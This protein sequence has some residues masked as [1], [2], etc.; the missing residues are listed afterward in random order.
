M[1]RHLLLLAAATV[2]LASCG[3]GGGGSTGGGDTSVTPPPP[4]SPPP[5]PPPPPPPVASR[6]ASEWPGFV[7]DTFEHLFTLDPP[8]AVQEGRHEFDGRLPDWS[9]AGIQQ[10]GLFWHSTLDQANAFV[11]LDPAQSFER[12]Y[13]VQIAAGQ[14]F[15]LEDVD[16]PHTAPAFYINDGLDPDVYLSREYAD[17]L[18]RMQA[19]TAMLE[20]VPAA[21]TNIRANL[22]LPLAA[23]M[24]ANA[25][26]S[27]NGFSTYYRNNIVPVFAG[28]GDQAQRT[29]LANA[30]LAAANAMTD[31]VAFLQSGSG[32]TVPSFAFGEAKFLKMLNSNEAIETSLAELDS[33]AQADLQRNQSDLA[34]A[35]AT[36]APGTSNLNCILAMHAH[37][38]AGD[39]LATATSQIA[40]LRA[41]VSSHDLVTIPNTLTAG[42]RASPPYRGGDYF[43]PVGPYEQG[44]SAYYYVSANGGGEANRL[45]VTAHEVM[46]GHFLQFLHSNAAPS[47]VGR[48]F[49]TYGF[50][51][52]WGHYGEEML[53]EA[54]LRGTAE[55]HVG[56]LFN[57]LLRNCRLLAAIG[58]HTKGMSITQAQNLFQ[59]QCY[60]GSGTSA[61]EAQ[62]AAFDPL[63]VTYTLGKLMIRRLR[64]DWTATRGGT[65]AWKAFHDQFLSYGGPPIPLVRQAMMAESAPLTRF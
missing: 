49:V 22:H 21:T 47:Q 10:I 61:A 31:L 25:V 24:Q 35:C 46:P 11:G 52:G 56:Q 6:P 2:A 34:S 38:P 51:E 4:P 26:A 64:A 40:E 60:Q 45:F 54:G 9:A 33:V 20:A 23:P 30:A 55:A 28:V 42:V 43:S 53:W 27:F 59:Q 5:P 29:R 1:R 19:V 63:V 41:F 65:S 48:L 57:A 16:Q 32:G 58:I 12:A 17:P 13:L 8:Y 3:G 39:P 37:T 7:A 15:W 14:L 18:T 36:F 50:A 44:V 62:R